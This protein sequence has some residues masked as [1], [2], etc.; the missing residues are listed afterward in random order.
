MNL[1]SVIIYESSVLS[2][3]TK[4]LSVSNGLFHR[5]LKLES[6]VE[7]ARTSQRYGLRKRAFDDA[8]KNRKYIASQFHT[9]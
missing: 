8:Y 7:L 6:S 2:A 3:K 4:S 1:H 5:S 9:S